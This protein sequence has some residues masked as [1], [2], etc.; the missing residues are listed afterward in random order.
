MLIK[1]CE[2]EAFKDWT[3][4]LRFVQTESN[5]NYEVCRLRLLQINMIFRIKFE[6]AL[7]LTKIFREK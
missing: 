1:H 5:W 2:S 7:A 6:S 4:S 3:N